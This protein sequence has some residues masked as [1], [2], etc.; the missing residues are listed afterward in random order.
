[1]A[2][3]LKYQTKNFLALGLL[4]LALQTSALSQDKSKVDQ[5]SD[6]LDIPLEDLLK[7]DVT[8]AF[9]SSIPVMK[10][11]AAIYVVNQ[12]MIQ[13]SGVK[14]LPEALRLVPGVEVSRIGNVYYTVSI[15]G[16]GDYLAS[17]KILVLLDGRTL[18]SPYQNTVYW[19]IE[20]LMMEDIDRIEVIMG[21][22]GSL[23]GAN[24]VNGVINVI[25]K[26]SKETK[27]GLA[28][29]T[30]GDL[31]RN[32]SVFRF[33][34]KLTD[35][36]TYRVYGKY[37]VNHASDNANGSSFGDSNNL[38]ALGF[39]SDI[40]L[41][42][43]ST[44]MIE[45][46][47]GQYHITEDQPVGLV[48]PPYNQ[49]FTNTDSIQTRHLLGRWSQE[50]EQGG[51]TSVQAY[52]DV[53]DYPYT[54]QGSRAE[55]YDLQV[56]RRVPV[57]HRNEVAY[58]GGYRY[59]VNDGIPGHSQTLVPLR[60]KDSIYNG[61]VQDIYHLSKMDNLTLGLKVEHNDVSGF[62][63][64]PNLR[65][66][67][68]PDERHTFWA[69]VGKA[70]RTPSQSELNTFSIVSVTPPSGG[71]P[72]PVATA[73]I[74]T[75]NLRPETVV[76]NEI[77]YRQKLNDRATLDAQAF[78]N[79]Y[80]NL[81][82][83]APGAQFTSSIF[84]TPVV[85]DPSYFKNGDSGRTYGGEVLYRYDVGSKLTTDLSVT[86]LQRSHFVQG[87]ELAGP[88]YQAA[89]HVGYRPT[90]KIDLD[91][92][93]HWNDAIFESG[94][95]SYLKLDLH[96]N[97][98]FSDYDEVGLGGY[99]LLTPRHFEFALGSYIQRSFALEYRRRF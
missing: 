63:Y 2:G 73:N 69:A 47:T 26:H 68:I 49:S 94:V 48:T 97:L 67:Y 56:D 85:I 7:V 35:D 37:G 81:I 13:R 33:G 6:L 24:A 10:V 39:R 9:K 57:L 45:G 90:N 87:S 60:R 77:G 61:F 71:Q 75:A 88:R 58:G 42:K 17:N 11:P 30:I 83:L 38:N 25:T 27:G 59:M 54:D 8:D 29:Q 28:V 72:L 1:M 51:K 15:R 64:Q 40:S 5:G 3:E 12:E 31:I 55:M 65:Y 98:R 76:S 41:P 78:Y 74:G 91:A 99:D 14:S 70:D 32:R 4:S 66:S 46:E 96:L 20:D 82:Y 80:N 19:E 89:W 21:P 50:Q 93:F 23:W 53:I 36:I 79:F 43:N 95:P 44:L 18:Y 62:E 84:G 22:G 86:Y 16:F 52:Y 92:R 34:D